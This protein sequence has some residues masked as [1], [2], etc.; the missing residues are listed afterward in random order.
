MSWPTDKELPL[1]FIQWILDDLGDTQVS[2]DEIKSHYV[3]WT[4]P[5]K[6]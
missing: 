6:P 3:L 4:G 1:D 5:D 2:F